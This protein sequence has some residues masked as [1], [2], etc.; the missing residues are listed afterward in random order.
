[1]GS[2][3]GGEE[4][5]KRKAMW[6][7]PKVMGFKPP[8][9]W[10]HS[11]CF[12]EGMV[13]LFGGCCGGLHFS[14]VLTL[15]LETMVWSTLP[16][17]GQKPGSRDSHSAVIVGHFMAVLGGTNGSKK[18][19]DLH[20]LDLRTKEWSKPICKGIPPTPRESH[21]TTLVGED[22]LVVFGGSGEGEANYLNDVHVLDLK[23][24]TWSSPELKGDPPAPRDSHTAVAIGSKLLIYGGDCGDHYHGEVDILDMDTMCWSRLVISGSSPGV[25]AGHATVSIGTKVYIIGGV[26]DKQY[27]SDVWVLN[28]TSCA[29]TQLEIC[30]QQSQGRFSHTA[31]VANA[32]IVIFG[33]C[34]EDERPLNELLILQLGSEHPN[35]RYN[36]SMCKVFRSHWSQDKRKFLQAY[37][38]KNGILKSGDPKR[39]PLEVDAEHKGVIFRCRDN[40]NTKRKRANDTNVVDV[41][42]EQ[43]EHSL[44]LSQ[45][46]SP[47][48][49]DQEQNTS[50]KL[51]SDKGHIL[52]Q[53][54]PQFTH[55]INP[56]KGCEDVRVIGVDTARKSK[57]E[58][59]L[60]AAPPRQEM[61]FLPSEL[62]SQPV[63]QGVPP[64]FGVEVRGV[65]DGA[66]DSGYLMTAS[67]NGHILRGVLFAPGPN[68]AVPRHLGHHQNAPAPSPQNTSMATAIPINNTR[69]PLQFV[70]PQECG[71]RIRNA[72]PARVMKSQ[73][74]RLNGDQ[75]VVLSLAG[76]AS[77]SHGIT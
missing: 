35:G 50:Q 8:E 44:S 23:T 36:I 47:S 21:T 19:N 57:T 14:D 39:V 51:S 70:M 4:A 42:S 65:V 13:Y 71:N 64:L 38:L 12:S 76:P 63:K 67:V 37:N 31:V 62:K 16:T 66:F 61:Q 52:L 9:R 33:G 56:G 53:T 75:G 3:S 25:R 11:A 60:R 7:Y 34:G 55:F 58:E 6:L 30:G 59:F 43:E 40:S 54:K 5:A 17:I 18:V 74:A 2:V 41:E 29:W 1:M 20:V 69:P 77:G 32:D 22:K 45:H 46:S 72:H 48:Q 26:G 68:V 49:S 27:Y 10:G 73:P 28:M 24:M 15:N